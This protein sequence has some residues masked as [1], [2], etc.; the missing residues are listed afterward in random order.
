MFRQFKR[1][2]SES[3]PIGCHQ[4]TIPD[5]EFNIRPVGSQIRTIGAE[6]IRTKRNA[7]KEMQLDASNVFPLVFLVPTC[8][9]G[10]FGPSVT[11]RPSDDG[12]TTAATNSGVG[13]DVGSG[14]GGGSGHGRDSCLLM[15]R[16]TLGQKPYLPKYN[17]RQKKQQVKW[18]C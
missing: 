17:L 3:T 11:I 13:L 4:L 15:V 1:A 2:E 7:F 14:G 12:L 18:A 8:A 6:H 16:L 10:V 9:A 5:G